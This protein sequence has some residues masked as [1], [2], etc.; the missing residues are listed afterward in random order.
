MPLCVYFLFQIV[1]AY[2]CVEKSEFSDAIGTT[3]R[4]LLYYVSVACFTNMYFDT[5]FGFK[6]LRVLSTII[7]LYLFVQLLFSKLGI[8]L[9][10]YLPLLRPIGINT[11]EVFLYRLTH[12][13]QYQFRPCSLLN[14]PAHVCTYLLLP[15]VLELFTRKRH[16]IWYSALY[17]VTCCVSRSS[18]GIIGTVLILTLY[19]CK[20]L[21][22]SK[23]RY[24]IINISI[25]AI[26][27][28]ILGMVLLFKTGIW[29]YFLNR[30]FNGSISLEGLKNSTR[31]YAL[32][33]TL[34]E[35]N[36]VLKVLFGTTLKTL[37]DF[38]PS[39]FRIYYCLGLIGLLIA[40]KL[41][42]KIW[43]KGDSVQRMSTLL[44]AILNVGTE[45]MLGSFVLL[46]IPFLIDEN[47][48]KNH[49]RSILRRNYA[50][51]NMPYDNI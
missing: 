25:A 42:L 40:I 43:S 41:V 21:K 45:M 3:A 36:T 48:T 19:V 7:S 20:I 18:T 35:S 30:T 10:S 14:E 8:Y 9:S 28:S 44:F 26:T 47:N 31:F 39:L 4:I 38:L 2:L 11:D 51:T 22:Y 46:Y 33:L 49:Q 13:Q 15:L 16:W 32:E 6:C 24:R 50:R 17:A 37:S 27:V 29:N 23:N 12:L 1:Y 34:Q 5:E